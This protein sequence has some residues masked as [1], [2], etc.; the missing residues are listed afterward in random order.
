MPPHYP[1]SKRK[2]RRDLCLLI[3]PLTKRP[4]TV[5]VSLVHKAHIQEHERVKRKDELHIHN[6]DIQAERI[7]QGTYQHGT[8]GTGL[9]G[10]RHIGFVG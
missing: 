6:G 1:D 3:L 4:D 2:N 8:K 10:E 7:G 9:L 5:E